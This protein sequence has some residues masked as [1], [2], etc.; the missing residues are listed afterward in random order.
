MIYIFLILSLVSQ[1]IAQEKI[2]APETLISIPAN[3]RYSKRPLPDRPPGWEGSTKLLFCGDVMF[4]W[5]IRET[6]DELGTVLPFEELGAMFSEADFRLVN[7]ETPILD[8]QITG[9]R[10]K[11]Y[12]FSGK[13][14]DLNVLKTLGINAVYL[15]NNHTMDFGPVGLRNTMNALEE[16]SIGFMGA[17]YSEKEANQ[18]GKF[19]IKNTNY[20]IF[21]HSRVGSPH[22]F[23]Q[24]IN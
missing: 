21:S 13:K 14:T 23:A 18:P 2:E 1:I 19:S 24:A 4:D 7:L 16:S 3:I 11:S 10:Q 12:V 8:Q 17:G 20:Y 9:E 6:M 22:H 5:G 15:G